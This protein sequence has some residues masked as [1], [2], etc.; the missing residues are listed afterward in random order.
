M[1]SDILSKVSNIE[2]NMNPI[3]EEVKVQLKEIR[4]LSKAIDASYDL[5]I[6]EVRKL[7]ALGDL[8]GADSLLA[9]AQ[10]VKAEL[11]AAVQANTELTAEVDA[12]NG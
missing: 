7:I 10:E 12:A 9:E 6:P 2:K 5:L 11:I 3:L 4:D 1:L 8:T